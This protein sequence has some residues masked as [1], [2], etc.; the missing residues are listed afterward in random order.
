[1]AIRIAHSS[2]KDTAAAAASLKQQVEGTTP[3][4]VVFFASSHYDPA[5]L[6]IA[7][8]EVFGKRMRELNSHGTFGSENPFRSTIEK[9]MQ[10]RNLRKE[11]V[12]FLPSYCNMK[13][14]FAG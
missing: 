4:F 6:G 12:L 10:Y 5:A 13:S 3:A 11:N 14:G 7:L 9:K 1:M 8:K 2:Q